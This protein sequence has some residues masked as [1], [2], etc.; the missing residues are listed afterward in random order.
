MEQRLLSIEER[1]RMG[2]TTAEIVN[3]LASPHNK[4]CEEQAKKTEQTCFRHLSITKR[5]ARTYI[6]KVHERLR[7]GTVEHD[8]ILRDQILALQFRCY[9]GAFARGDYNTASNILMKIARLS[10]II[11]P[12]A[13]P[14]IVQLLAGLPSDRERFPADTNY[15]T[16]ALLRDALLAQA[17]KGNKKAAEL[18]A[19]ISATLV[20]AYGASRSGLTNEGESEIIATVRA[21][22]VTRAHFPG[23][24]VE[25]IERFDKDGKQL[26]A[27]DDFQ[28]LETV[29]PDEESKK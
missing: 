10:G 15:Q 1:L 7:V 24:P 26:P 3:E 13:P 2:L 19:A 23:G 11:E 4:F 9:Q 22:L 18:A 21:Q 6:A 17:A 27:I 20:D 29:A 14:Q 8:P 5:Q 28:A 12:P 16:Q 25:P